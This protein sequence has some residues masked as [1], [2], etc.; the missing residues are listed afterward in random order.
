M[1]GFG[2]PTPESIKLFIK[3]AMQNWAAPKPA[4]LALIGD[5]DYDY[6]GYILKNAGVR[7]GENYVPSYGNPVSDNWYV[8]FDD[9]IPIPQLKVGRLPINNPEELVITRI[10]I[11]IN[12]NQ[13]FSEWNKRYIFF[14]GAVSLLNIPFSNRLMIQ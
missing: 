12:E 13:S 4:Y 9:N 7:L 2:Y 1:Y 8:I 14:S 3:D 10:K 6:K 5:A 11:D